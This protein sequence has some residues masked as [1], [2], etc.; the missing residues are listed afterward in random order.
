MGV[1]FGVCAKEQ[2]RFLP[3]SCVEENL[4]LLH[5]KG[6]Q[7]TASTF[8]VVIFYDSDW[9]PTVDQ[10]AMDRAH[11]LGQTKQVT[12]Y[13]LICK[14]TIEERILQRAREKSEEAATD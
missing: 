13:R 3:W 1:D 12:V 5:P 10:Q 4:I 6:Q 7:S 14:G 8:V 11:R 9:N 2:M